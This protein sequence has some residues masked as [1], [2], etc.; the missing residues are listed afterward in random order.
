MIWRRVEYGRRAT[1]GRGSWDNY[2]ARG[3]ELLIRRLEAGD[4]HV[5]VDLRRDEAG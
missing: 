5:R 2:R 4:A 1:S 3:C